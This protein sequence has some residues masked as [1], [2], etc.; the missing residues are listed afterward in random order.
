MVNNNEIDKE[1]DGFRIKEKDRRL[2]SLDIF[3]N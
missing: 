2:L 3:E 1:L